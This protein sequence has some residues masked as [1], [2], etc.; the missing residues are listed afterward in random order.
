MAPCRLARPRPAVRVAPPPPPGGPVLLRFL[1]QCPAECPPPASTPTWTTPTVW[2]TRTAGAATPSACP[3][4]KALP[5]PCAVWT[6][7]GPTGRAYAEWVC[8]S[9]RPSPPP[10]PPQCCTG[11]CCRCILCLLVTG[12]S[13]RT[14]IIFCSGQPLSITNRQQPPTTANRQPPPTANR[15]PPTAANRQPMFNTVS[16]VFVSCPYLNHEAEGVP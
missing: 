2:I 1:V 15:Q 8:R 12:L 7:S 14:P 11:A 10:S 5:R 3:D 16:V 4:I 9:A 13:L 6:G